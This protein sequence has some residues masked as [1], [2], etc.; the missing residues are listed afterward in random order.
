M[1]EFTIDCIVTDDIKKAQLS[2]EDE[3]KSIIRVGI[4]RVETGKQEEVDVVKVILRIENGDEFY[5][6]TGSDRVKV[7][8]VTE[9]VMDEA[10]VNKYIRT[11]KDGKGNNNLLNRPKCS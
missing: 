3:Y 9:K 6:V 7:E 2:K 8:V 4:T 5:V 11:H 10:W 1:A